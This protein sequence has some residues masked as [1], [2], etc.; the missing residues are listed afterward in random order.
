MLSKQLVSTK[1]MPVNLSANFLIANKFL[2][3]LR[4]L[5][6][7][8]TLGPVRFEDFRAKTTG[9]HVVLHRNFS[10]LVSATD[11]VKSSKDS[12]SLAVCNEK[13]FVGWG[14]RIFC[15]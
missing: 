11:L 4:I 5:I 7:K 3:T 12:V 14:M 9:S 15:E 13:K 6:P 8:N 1:K 2:V 10:G